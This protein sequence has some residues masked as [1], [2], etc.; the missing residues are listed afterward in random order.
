MNSATPRLTGTASTIAIS[1]GYSVPHTNGSAPNTWSA[2]DHRVEL[3]NC[4]PNAG[5]ARRVM[6]SAIMPRIS[7]TRPAAATTSTLNARSACCLWPRSSAR[8]IAISSGHL[9]L[10]ELG[11]RLVGQA[12]GQ[13]REVEPLELGLA[14]ADE[15]LEVRL[16]RGALGVIGLLGVDDHP[17]LVGDRVG[18]VALGVERAEQQVVL[19]LDAVAGGRRGVRA[20]RDELAALVLDA[21]ERQPGGLGVRQV[22]VA[23]RALGRLHDLRD[24]GVTVAG[25]GIG[26]PLD[27][28]AGLELPRVLGGLVEVLGEVVGR[29]RA[30][31]AVGDDDVGVGQL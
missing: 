12:L 28:R 11:D 18:R 9:D 10:V 13:R 1:A 24:A 3:K 7:S 23:D 31:G 30:I 17:A 15:E 20:R 6:T 16:E 8:C 25:L 21:R 4:A 26:R 22:D 5:H 2:A 27:G 29:A 14:V 19:D